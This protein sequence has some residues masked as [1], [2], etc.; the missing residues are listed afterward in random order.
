MARAGNLNIRGIARVA[1]EPGVSAAFA[2]QNGAFKDVTREDAGT[3][4]VE[5]DEESLYNERDVIR[6]TP[7]SGNAF[8]FRVVER[9]D[10]AR[11]RVRLAVALGGGSPVDQDFQISMT[12]VFVG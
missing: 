4:L 8:T 11:F 2:S 1:V 3:F 12:E 5:M 6:I 10:S 9:I 7:D